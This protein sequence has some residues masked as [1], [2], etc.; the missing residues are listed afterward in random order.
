TLLQIALSHEDITLHV[1]RTRDNYNTAHAE[2]WT[3]Q[4]QRATRDLLGRDPH[5]LPEDFEVHVVSSNTH[6][7]TNCLSPWLWENAE[8]VR[9][10]GEVHEPGI[11]AGA[12]RDP[13]DLLVAL[14]RPF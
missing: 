5:D 7:V 14:L 11:C 9:A 10:W 1:D 2:A 4:I 3:L 12:W 8:R 6:S 13:S